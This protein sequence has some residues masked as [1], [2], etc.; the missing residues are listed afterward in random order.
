MRLTQVDRTARPGTTL[1][2]L[3]VAISLMVIIMGATLPIVSSI[4][5]SWEASQHS[6]DALQN[7]RVLIDHLNHHLAQAIKVTAISPTSQTLGYLEFEDYDGNT[8]RYDVDVQGNVEYGLAASQAD[9]AGPVSQFLFTCYDGNDFDTPITEVADIRYIQVQATLI[10]AASMGQDKTLSTSVYLQVN[11]NN[12]TEFSMG[13]P[14]EFDTDQGWDPALAQIDSTHSLCAYEGD[15]GDGWAT[16]LTVNPSTWALTRGTPFEFDT[17]DG[18]YPALAQIDSTHYLC[19]YT[20]DGDDGWATILT[21]DTDTWTITQETS[22]EFDTV[23]GKTPALAPIDDSHYLCAYTGDGD[24]GKAVVLTVGDGLVGHWKLDESSGS[25]AEDASGNENDGTLTNMNDSDWIT[26]TL[27]GAL[28]FDGYNDYVAV[29]HSD[30]F[31]ADNG[32]VALWFRGDD[33]SDRGEL[34]SKDSSGYDTGGH[35][36][37]WVEDAEVEVRF[38]GASSDYFLDSG[39]I[40]EEDT[41]YHMALSWGAEGLKLYLDGSEVDTDSYTGGLGTSSGGVGNYEPLALGACTWGS[42]NQVITPLQYYFDGKLD[43]VRFYNYAL[44]TSEVAALAATLS[45]HGGM[46]AKADTETSAITLSKPLGT[47]AGDLLISAVATDGDTEASLTP[48]AGEGWTEIDLN[49]NSGAVTLGTWWKLAEASESAT[50]EFT[51]SGTEQ[52]YAWMMRFTGHNSANP[53]DVSAEAGVTGSSPTSPAV[54]STVDNALVLRLG[55]FDDREI[56]VDSPGLPGHMAITMDSSA[57]SGDLVAQWT[58]DESSG[59]TATDASG[60]GHNGTLTNMSGTEWT[61]GTLD[62]ALRFDGS[63]D[64]VSCGNFDVTGGDGHLTLC[65]WMKAD[66]FGTSDARFISK[67]TGTATND[68]YWMLSTVNGSKLRFRLKTNGS[69]TEL[70]SNGGVLSSGTWTHVAATWDG[71]TMRVFRNAI[72]V[73]STSKSGTLSTSGS[74]GVAIGNQP[75]GAGI[76][77]FDGLIDDVRIY[78]QALDAAELADVAAGLGGGPPVTSGTVSGGA[79]YVRQNSSGSSGTSTFSLTAAEEACT[80]TLAIAPNTQAGSTSVSAVTKGTTCEIT[81]YQC[82]EPA[83]IQ[84]DSTHYLCAMKGPNDDGWAKVLIVDPSTWAISYGTAFEFDNSKCQT[85]ALSQ[86]DATHFLCIYAGDGDDGYAVVLTVNTSTWT[87]SK[88]SAFEFDEDKGKEPA[89]VSMGS[90]KFLCAYRGDGDDGF[91][92]VLTVDTDTWTISYQSFA[93]EF[94]TQAG[95]TPALVQIDTDHYLCTYA[96]KHDDGWSV[97]LMPSA[98]GLSP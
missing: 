13:T 35:V 73:K 83:L 41:W 27:D 33:V 88:G 42:G 76:K 22:L 75:S 79:G 84:I 86:I 30:E 98:T 50:H 25:T 49:S 12:A 36:T 52:A 93:F 14:F 81:P 3:V 8:Q 24:T 44:D 20:G 54:T 78:N 82:K 15:D 68:H 34:F 95:Y 59:T 45:Y 65:A 1:I 28:D 57:S 53:I 21:V 39:E 38:Q 92:Q 70:K 66:D 9:L 58:F 51:W 10:N 94:D 16:V 6:V 4:R 32:T 96:G 71:S 91:S 89:L 55:A 74:V 40:I 5:K 90:N 61:T 72:E 23:K 63:N 62:G 19:A 11:S 67:A 17:D 85:P 48:P 60:N 64:L 2:E 46:E 97:V 56:S 37:I 26:G 87:I 77:A 29:A 18:W 80:L 43:D 31:L 7:G 47:N 69:T